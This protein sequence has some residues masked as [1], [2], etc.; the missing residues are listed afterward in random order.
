MIAT[1]RDPNSA[2]QLRAIARPTEDGCSVALGFEGYGEKT[3]ADGYG[4]P[5]LVELY[6]GRLTLHVWADI[7]SENPT[8]SIDLEGAREDA[9]MPEASEVEAL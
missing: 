5:V 6:N 9:R 4:C 7:N 1:L 8:H 2:R 3:A